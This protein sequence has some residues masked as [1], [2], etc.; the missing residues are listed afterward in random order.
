MA[1]VQKEKG[2]TSIANELIEAILKFNCS[3]NQKDI[4]WTIIR[5]T[6]GYQ[7]KE[8]D[9][10]VSYIAKA[11]NSDKAN[12]SRNLN[13]LIRKNVVVVIAEQTNLAPRKL[14]LN[15]DYDTW[16]VVKTTTPDS[17]VG[18]VKT[19][20]PELSK[21][22]PQSCQN[23]NAGVVKITTNKENINKTIKKEKR[24]A[25]PKDDKEKHK[26]LDEIIQIFT[27]EFEKSRGIGYLVTAIGKERNAVGALLQAH[28]AK[29]KEPYSSEQTKEAFR[30]LF[31]KCLE[32]KDNWHTDKMSIPHI[33]YNI[34]ELRKKINES[35][36]SRTGVGNNKQFNQPK[37]VAGFEQFQQKIS[38]CI[39]NG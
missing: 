16:G 9:I 6:Y 30:I 11:T 2:F 32:I 35:N 28:K 38:K 14:A 23:N 37:G 34:N 8:T 15:K 33:A 4:I 21:Q 5:N 22:Q 12:I 13:E 3:G 31:Q 10:S 27:E 17:E 26:F 25:T 20:T 29:T 24:K 7:K 19:T 36:S 18:V 1:D 39:N